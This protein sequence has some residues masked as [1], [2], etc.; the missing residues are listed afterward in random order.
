MDVESWGLVFYFGIFALGF[1]GG[2]A[3]MACFAL[4]GKSDEH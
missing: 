1:I 3:F 4:A 2:V